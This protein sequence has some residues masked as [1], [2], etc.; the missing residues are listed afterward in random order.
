[1]FDENHGITRN[2]TLS[3]AWMRL[4]K[5][6]RA[7]LQRLREE[8]D[9]GDEEVT[10]KRRGRIAEIKDLLAFTDEVRSQPRGLDR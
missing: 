9:S 6:F 1:M 3:P 8:N 10:A 7:R 4:E 2:D 5:A